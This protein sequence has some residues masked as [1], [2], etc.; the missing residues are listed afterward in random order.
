MAD[1]IT[2]TVDPIKTKQIGASAFGV[3]CGQASLTSYS[4]SKTA[5]TAITGLF[6]PSTTLLRVVGGVSSNGYSIRW[7]DTAQAFRAYGAAANTDSIAL[8]AP[9]A[10]GT[11]ALTGSPMTIANAG[12]VPEEIV[13]TGGTVTSI[14]RN[15]GT[16]TTASM[17]TAG[18]FH[19]EVGDNLIVTYTGTPA[20]DQFPA[21][22]YTITDAG[23]GALS[24]VANATNVGLIDFIAMGQMG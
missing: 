1:T 21:G 23:A 2:V 20:L 13:V 8:G 14:T 19:L 3:V 9:A 17:G 18:S 12:T 24:E 6:M 10:A 4:S 5:L 15:R 16:L 22:A 11:I 7:D